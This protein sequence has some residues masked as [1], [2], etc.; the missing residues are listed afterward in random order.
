MADLHCINNQFSGPNCEA[1][2]DQQLPKPTL[3]TCCRKTDEMKDRRL[4]G[5]G[6]L[7][8]LT[9]QSGWRTLT[10]PGV[11]ADHGRGSA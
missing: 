5:G 10:A 9:E 8:E 2:F 6:K 4:R 3:G 11:G 7:N 1:P